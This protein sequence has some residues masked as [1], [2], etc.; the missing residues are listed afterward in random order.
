MRDTPLPFAPA[1]RAREARNGGHTAV[2]PAKDRVGDILRLRGF[3]DAQSDRL[4]PVILGQ[5]FKVDFV[6]LVTHPECL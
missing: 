2:D 3:R 5:F 1:R 6:H 4:R